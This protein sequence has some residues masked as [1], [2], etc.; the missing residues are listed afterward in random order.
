MWKQSVKNKNDVMSPWCPQGRL[1]RDWTGKSTCMTDVDPK[2]E[3]W[4]GWV[5]CARSQP[6]HA[7]SQL[8]QVGSSSQPGIEPRSPELT[9]GIFSHWTPKV[10][11]GLVLNETNSLSHLLMVFG[12]P[13]LGT[14]FSPSLSLPILPLLSPLS[15][16]SY[17]PPELMRSLIQEKS[18]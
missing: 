5:G 4:W 12:H 7:N 10:V 13:L 14:H 17:S 9:A 3:N 1:W 15:L 11:L 18:N 2:W 6:W 8:Q 16:S